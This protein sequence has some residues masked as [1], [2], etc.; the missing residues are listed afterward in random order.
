MSCS[1]TTKQPTRGRPVGLLINPDAARYVLGNRSQSWWAIEANVSTAHLSE[2]LKG[3]KGVAE[4]VAERLANTL[5]VPIGVLFP[6]TVQ[7]STQVRHFSAPK[8]EAA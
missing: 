3:T 8:G 2:I 1:V 5:T 7:F 6:E 4:D